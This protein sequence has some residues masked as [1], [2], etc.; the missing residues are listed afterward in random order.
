M[1]WRN[2][3]YYLAAPAY[4][5]HDCVRRLKSIKTVKIHNPY[6]FN[7][8]SNNF[9]LIYPKFIVGVDKNKENLVLEVLQSSKYKDYRSIYKEITKEMIGQ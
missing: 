6:D 8:D 1:D 2:R 5:Y 7:K 9:G 3:K 4:S